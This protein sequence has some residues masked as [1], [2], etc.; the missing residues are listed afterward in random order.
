MLIFQIIFAFALTVSLVFLME[1]LAV[2][3]RW[4]DRPT[5][6]KRRVRPIPVTGGVA[7][8]FGMLLAASFGSRDEIN[9]IAV[10]GGY[11]LIGVV[12]DLIDMRP[13]VKLLSQIFVTLVIFAAHR[14]LIGPGD[15]LGLSHMPLPAL[16]WIT[17]LVFVVGLSNAF[18][19]LDG[20]DGLAAGSA[21][22]ILV[23]L[24]VA[25]ALLGLNGILAQIMCL[26]GAVLGFLWLNA[27]HPWRS[28]ARVYLGDAGSLMLG[29]GIALFIVE[30]ATSQ[31][32]TP[33]AGFPVPEGLP[34][35]PMLLWLVALPVF[36]TLILIVRRLAAG[37]SPLAGDRWHV[38][39]VLVDAGLSQAAA[40]ALL[41]GICALNGAIGL[42]A[43]Y[44]GA[45]NALALVALVLPLAAHLFIVTC[46]WQA[47]EAFR[48]PDMR[49]AGAAV[50]TSRTK[51]GMS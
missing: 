22:V 50:S 1:P 25:A 5:A 39:H 44:M 11:L 46:S 31:A 24:A 8:F 34:S 18:N 42:L 43:W 6:L 27:R 15:V 16:E 2:S 17:T 49:K 30:I 13:L 7:I 45:P 10:I 47:L 38:H 33:P 48:V 9:I 3:W 20:I 36:D 4:T 21:S 23:C 29:A 12:D 32:G 19:M 51:A 26:L 28:S 14:R 40:A 41:V 37:R 35:M